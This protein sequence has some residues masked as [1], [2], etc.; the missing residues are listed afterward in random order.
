MDAVY[1]D[2]MDLIIVLHLEI[3]QKKKLLELAFNI[4]F[5]AL[6]KKITNFRFF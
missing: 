1:D 6:N 5:G 2:A 4:N 3:E